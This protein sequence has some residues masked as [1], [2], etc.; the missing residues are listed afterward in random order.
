MEPVCKIAQRED[1]ACF[2]QIPDDLFDRPIN[3]EYLEQFL[4]DDRHHI[5]I[6]IAKGAVVG[7]VSAVDY[8]HPDKPRELWINEVGV[9]EAW[10][11]QGIARAL[12]QL[13]FK[14]GKAIGCAEAWVLTEP[15]NAPA[16][17]LYQSLANQTEM[18]TTSSR[19]YNFSCM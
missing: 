7:F 15:D 9:S 14:H 16:N 6:A 8:L 10:Q 4:V 13:M 1:V 17:A 18:D 3:T 19:M 5:A 12:M 2:E 11:R